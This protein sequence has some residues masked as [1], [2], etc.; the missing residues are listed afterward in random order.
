M[1][2]PAPGW[3]VDTLLSLMNERDQRYDQRF[4]AQEKAVTVA[5]E[6][7]KTA[8]LKAENAMEKRFDNTNEWRQTLNDRDIKL[9]PRVE[10]DR[11]HIDLEKR[12]EE[13]KKSIDDRLSRLTEVQTR[14]EAK[15]EV[16]AP[17]MKELLSEVKGLR[18][19]RSGTEGEKKGISGLFATV[20]GVGWLLTI[21]IGIYTFAARPTSTP[22]PIVQPA[23]I[24]IMPSG[25]TTGVT[26][27]P[28]PVLVPGAK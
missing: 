27:S 4:V 22:A 19:T 14:A 12:L 7:A 9:L 8:G 28:S 10:Y 20:L 23:P 17:A 11:A 5:I 21:L 25:A 26:P 18:D 13:Y 16:T 2:K 6:G 3:T 1:E 24:I 15:G